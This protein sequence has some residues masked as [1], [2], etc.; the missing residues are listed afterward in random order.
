MSFL[1]TL[2]FQGAQL[3]QSGLFDLP[4]GEFKPH[5]G[6]WAYFKNKQNKQKHL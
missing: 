2:Q 4:G 6:H 3:A 1:K 5:I